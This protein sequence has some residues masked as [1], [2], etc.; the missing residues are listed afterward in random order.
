MPVTYHVVVTFDR[1]DE[2]DLKAGEAREA[3]NPWPRSAP[4]A[5]C[6]SSMPARWPFRVP[7]SRPPDNSRTPSSWRDSAMLSLTR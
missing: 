3:P 2:G 6:R 7:A 1:D 5:A 4:P